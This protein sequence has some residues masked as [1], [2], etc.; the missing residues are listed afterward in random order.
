M[1][2]VGI[3]LGTTN[4][5]VTAFVGGESILIPNR[6]G[7]VLTPS[8]VSLDNK[9]EII[10]GKMAKDRLITNPNLAAAVF[11]RKM[12]TDTGIKLGK[13]SFLPEELSSF[14]LYQLLVGWSDPVAPTLLPIKFNH[15][16]V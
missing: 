6:H 2:I 10:V 16:G 7:E 9:N 5:L 12:G 4:S 3:D 13:K 15:K 1:A 14:M 8:I 11:K